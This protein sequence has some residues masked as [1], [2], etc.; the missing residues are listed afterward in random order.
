MTARYAISLSAP[1]EMVLRNAIEYP[2]IKQ[3]MQ[4][5]DVSPGEK[6]YRRTVRISI[7]RNEEQTQTE[8]KVIELGRLIFAEWEKLKR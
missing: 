3:L 2:E 6:S 8:E 4:E 1:D 5:L 7:Y